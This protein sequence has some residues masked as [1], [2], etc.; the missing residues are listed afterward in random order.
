MST[1]LCVCEKQKETW[2][3]EPGVWWDVQRWDGV[4]GQQEIDT[5]CSGPEITGDRRSILTSG[6]PIATFENKRLR[7]VVVWRAVD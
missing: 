2:A 4:D 6:Y 3:C 1:S 5:I 7:D